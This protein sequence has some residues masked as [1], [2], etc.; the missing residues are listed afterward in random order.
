MVGG[1][2]ALAL[3]SYLAL[4]GG[5]PML[6]A[7]FG[8]SCAILFGMPDSRAARPRNL[9]GGHTISAIVAVL[10]VAVMGC[11]V[12]SIP[13]AV[14]ASVLLMIATD[15]LHPPGGATALFGVASAASPGYIL[16]PTMVGVAI[17]LI[18][19]LITRRIH[20]WSSGLRHPVD[21][22]ACPGDDVLVLRTVE[23]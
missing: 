1:F 7:S 18:V 8:A 6:L 2:I 15:T 23:R 9:V 14:M 21:D 3:I 5:A 4:H 19:A 22:R 13:I 10:T 11:T 20:D 12:I 17:L 16:M